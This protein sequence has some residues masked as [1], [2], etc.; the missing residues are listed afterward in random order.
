[1]DMV[2]LFDQRKAKFQ[3]AELVKALAYFTF[4]THA[5]VLAEA[6]R[7]LQDLKLLL[8]D[9]GL[10]TEVAEFRSSRSSSPLE[11]LGRCSGMQANDLLGN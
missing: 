3:A 8:E 2:Q 7:F 10:F 9:A 5:L 6:G 11:R 4:K 1:M